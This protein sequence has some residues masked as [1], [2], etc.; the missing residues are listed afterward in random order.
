MIYTPSRTLRSLLV[1]RDIG[2]IADQ[3]GLSIS[4]IEQLSDPDRLPTAADREHL[5]LL[6]HTLGVASSAIGYHTVM[7]RAAPS[8]DGAAPITFVMSTDDSDRYRDIVQQDFDLAGF[9]ANPVAPWNH[10]YSK[11]PIGRWVDVG[12]VDGQLRGSLEFDPN[13]DHQLAR[14]VEQQYR[15]GFLNTVSVGFMPG[16]TVRRNDLDEEDPLHARAGFVFSRNTLLEAS[17]VVVPGNPGATAIARSD[18]KTGQHT[19]SWLV[20]SPTRAEPARHHWLTGQ[21][22]DDLSEL[23]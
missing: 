3:S 16:V 18:T 23:R 7:R 21:P 22:I 15:S 19:L 9:L 6:A 11:P 4:R 8:V 13:P 17:A 20:G 12:L 5:S 2:A 10:D 1:G 14:T